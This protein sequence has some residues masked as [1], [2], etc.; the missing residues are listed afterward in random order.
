ME[1]PAAKAMAKPAEYADL[2]ANYNK[3]IQSLQDRNLEE[4][5]RLFRLVV[6]KNKKF[7]DASIK[8][9]ECLKGRGVKHY[10]H[11]NYNA[12][13][14]DFQE[15]LKLNSQDP[16]LRKFIKNVE[17]MMDSIGPSAK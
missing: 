16:M 2:K 15:A 3:A 5:I 14:I 11:G 12:S 1:P 7:E 6:V 8:L 10:A 17:Q 13:L 9:S 4:A